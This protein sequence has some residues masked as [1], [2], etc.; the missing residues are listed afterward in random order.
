[1][2]IARDG[3]IEDKHSVGAMTGGDARRREIVFEGDYT[4]NGYA[5]HTPL[6]ES[7]QDRVSPSSLARV[8]NRKESGRN[9]LACQ[10]LMVRITPIRFV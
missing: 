1:M 6:S 5:P 4:W 2:L 7:T 9:E 10:W 3:E 8:E